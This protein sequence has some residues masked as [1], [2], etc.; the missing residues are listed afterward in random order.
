[1]KPSLLGQPWPAGDQTACV[2]IRA[3]LPASWEH[4]PGAAAVSVRVPSGQALHLCG[5]VDKSLPL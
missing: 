1:M 3:H 5:M 4:C 2:P